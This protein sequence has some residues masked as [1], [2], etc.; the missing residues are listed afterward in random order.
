MCGKRLLGM[1][2]SISLGQVS[3][4]KY[5]SLMRIGDIYVVF[6]PSRWFY[7]ASFVQQ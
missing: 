2:I 4:G 7:I 5:A 6:S 3:S 1:D